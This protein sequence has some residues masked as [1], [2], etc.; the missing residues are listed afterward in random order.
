[1]GS[2]DQ[3]KQEAVTALTTA[4][5]RRCETVALNTE[6]LRPRSSAAANAPALPLA[7]SHQTVRTA[8]ANVLETVHADELANECVQ[9]GLEP[10]RDGSRVRGE[11]ILE[12]RVQRP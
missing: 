10:Q 11:L 9:F 4:Y 1:M 7:V 3:T 5:S 6:L 2:C 12:R 8:I